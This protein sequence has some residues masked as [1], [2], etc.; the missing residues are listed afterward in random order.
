MRHTAA[1]LQRND[2]HSRFNLR[3]ISRT[4]GLVRCL[5]GIAHLVRR[6]DRVGC[7]VSGPDA[8]AHACQTRNES[9][10]NV[11]NRTA[12]CKG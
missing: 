12:T 1:H 6:P 8:G 9:A 3:S 2:G 10:D 11:T 5:G 7:L 4:V